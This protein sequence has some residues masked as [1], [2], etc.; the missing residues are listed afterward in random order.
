MIQCNR[1]GLQAKRRAASI[2]NYIL[3][4]RT[5]FINTNYDADAVNVHQRDSSQ[6]APIFINY[7]SKNIRYVLLIRDYDRSIRIHMIQ[8]RI[9]E[10][11]FGRWDPTLVPGVLS[12]HFY[13]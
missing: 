4:N 7:A 2:W 3:T 1:N 10:S 9:W 5:K 13:D 6:N 11:Y 8:C 12:Q